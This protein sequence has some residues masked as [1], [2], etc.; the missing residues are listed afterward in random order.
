MASAIKVKDSLFGQKQTKLL[1]DLLVYVVLS[2]VGV[3]F[4]MPFRLDGRQLV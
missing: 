2:I 4:I 3:I 1:M